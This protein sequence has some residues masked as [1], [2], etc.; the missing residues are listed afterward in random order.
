[1]QNSSLVGERS[2]VPVDSFVLIHAECSNSLEIGVRNTKD[3]KE[4][5]KEV[6][7]EGREFKAEADGGEETYLS[8]F[9]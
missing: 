8:S 4:M 9:K 3:L 2:N 6:R 5:R 1:M 7:R